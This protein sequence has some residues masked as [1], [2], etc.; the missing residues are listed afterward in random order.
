MTL[1]VLKTVNLP[2]TVTLKNAPA[3]YLAGN[4]N[5]SIYPASVNVGVPVEQLEQTK[6]ISIGTVDFSDLNAGNN[7]FKFS[8][9]SV[10]DYEINENIKNFRVTIN[11]GDVT[12]TTINIPATGV[13]IIKQNDKYQSVVS[14]QYINSVKIIGPA[15]EIAGLTAQDV[16]AEVDLSTTELTAGTNSVPVKITVKGASHCWAYGEYSV[17]ITATAK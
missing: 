5:M 13:S 9:D 17:N 7:T 12:N 14:S 2:T 6:Q 11:I 10:L 15:D 3:G 1:P 4:L 16:V 8:A